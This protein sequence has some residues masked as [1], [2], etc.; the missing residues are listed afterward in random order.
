MS[1][2]CLMNVIVT[3]DKC[4]TTSSFTRFVKCSK[5]TAAA[6][7]C[8]KDIDKALQLFQTN[9]QIDLWKRQKD[10]QNSQND[11]QKLI[12]EIHV[13]VTNPSQIPQPNPTV[14]THVL[15]TA[16]HIFC[17]R[18]EEVN[19]VVNLILNHGPAHV[20][21]VGAG[22]IGKTSIALH[23]IHHSDVKEHFQQ[24]QFFLSCEAISTADS[25]ALELLK[26]FGVSVD[27][28]SSRLPDTGSSR[29]PSDNLTL[30]MRS[31]KS[32]CLLCLD[33]FETP[34]DS[35]KDHVESLLRNIAVPDLTLVI[36][37]RD[38]D[39]PR[40]IK[41]AVLNVKTLAP[42]AAIET[43]DAISDGH[44]QFSVQLMEA[45]DN[46]PLAV[47]LLAQLA[48]IESSEELWNC[49]EANSTKLVTSDGTRH[50]LN[51]LE[52]SIELSLKSPRIEKYK[53]ALDF[54][55]VLCMLPQGMSKGRIT[56]FK[57]T[58]ANDLPELDDII[59][60]LKQCSLAYTRD[61]FLCVLSPIRQCILSHPELSTPLSKN[62]FGQM[63]E[64][65][66]ELIPNNP[67][68]FVASSVMKNI[69]LEIGNIRAVLDISI[70]EDPYIVGKTIQFC[71]VSQ[72]LGADETRLLL[73][74]TSTVPFRPSVRPMSRVTASVHFTKCSNGGGVC[75]H[76]ASVHFGKMFTGAHMESKKLENFA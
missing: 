58:V 7:K 40:G 42:D 18:E 1:Y 59:T 68:G 48:Q 60:V 69:Q 65:Y 4:K 30:H 14:S 39:R 34:W 67:D 9:L 31:M 11:S 2:E 43:W 28:S 64:V 13:V 66:F 29:S 15:P 6:Q 36:T 45:V 56:E 46:L 51:S 52:F 62:L 73:K 53:G 37:S 55:A 63:A 35:D 54:F 49:W 5:L 33:N 12:Q 19:Q 24:E 44:N 16:S 57:T 47:T 21:I 38:I 27:T 3:M 61:G 25:L 23:S 76:V 50:R 22:G 72:R 71:Q 41:W 74:A 17:G 26:L 70:T 8:Q 10:M 20:A 75:H 32:K